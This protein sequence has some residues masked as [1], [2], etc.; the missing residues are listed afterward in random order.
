MLL[1]SNPAAFGKW[2]ERAGRH[3]VDR[4]RSP[5]ERL[6]WINAWNEWAEGAHLEPDERYGYEWL[7]AVRD[8]QESVS[9]VTS[10]TGPGVAVIAHDL[11]RNGAQLGSL[12]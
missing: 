8:A 4:F 2:V 10:G 11:Q 12:A 5:D 7:H 3:T 9:G 6:I 1:G